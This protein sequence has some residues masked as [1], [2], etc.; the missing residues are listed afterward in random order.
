[1]Y[2]AV[3]LF[4]FFLNKNLFFSV[5]TYIECRHVKKYFFKISRVNS[6]ST[7]IFFLNR[8]TRR[9]DIC[10]KKK[11]EKKIGFKKNANAYSL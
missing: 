9:F 3:V 4:F 2:F 5:F 7:D 8:M 1:M 10:K 6:F 11:V